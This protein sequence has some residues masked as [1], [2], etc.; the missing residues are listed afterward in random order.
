MMSM[1][2][3]IDRTLPIRTITDGLS[4][5]ADTALAGSI[6]KRTIGLEVFQYM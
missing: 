5:I 1:S 3:L 2:L 4:R 6:Y